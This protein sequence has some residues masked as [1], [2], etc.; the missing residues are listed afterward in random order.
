MKKRSIWIIT[1]F[2]LILIVATMIFICDSKDVPEGAELIGEYISPRG[3]NSINVYLDS[4]ALS[5]DFVICEVED[6]NGDKKV[7]YTDYYYEP[8]KIAWESDTIVKIN[9]YELDIK[10]DVYDWRH[11]K[12]TSNQM[13]SAVYK[14]YRIDISDGQILE[15]EMKRDGILGGGTSFLKVKCKKSTVEEVKKAEGLSNLPTKKYLNRYL[16]GRFKTLNINNEVFA[17]RDGY[18]GL[19]DKTMRENI[20]NEDIFEAINQN[21]E[22]RD[23]D[24]DLDEILFFQFDKKDAVAY[25]FEQ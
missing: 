2:L 1:A 9:N 3:D 5:A 4:P 6:N 15:Y 7:I 10:K 19:Y 25:I 23:D 20:A 24:Y 13:I 18:Y 22:N 8:I 12:N 21:S 14:I 11:E 16:K 17:L